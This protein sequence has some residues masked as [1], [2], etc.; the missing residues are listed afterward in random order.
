MCCRW[1][2]SWAQ[3]L[4]PTYSGTYRSSSQ[5]SPTKKFLNLPG[6]EPPSSATSRGFASSLPFV[7]HTCTTVRSGFNSRKGCPMRLRRPISPAHAT[8]REAIAYL[9]SVCDGAIKRDGHGFAT[10]HVEVGHKLARARW[11]GP[12]ARR[13]AHR[14][15]RVYQSQLVRAGYDVHGLLNRARPARISRRAA[16]QVSAAWSSDPTGIRRFRYWNGMRWTPL[17]ADDLTPLAALRWPSE[18]TR[19]GQTGINPA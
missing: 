2:L 1:L 7:S 17:C 15:V 8:R 11:W 9:A 12:L 14:L 16:Q 13:R 4:K 5:A 10:E 6:A 18:S 19:S 3:R